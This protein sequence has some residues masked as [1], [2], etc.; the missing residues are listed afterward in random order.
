MHI[1]H[2][3][4]KIKIIILVIKNYDYYIEKSDKSSK[5]FII[6]N[7]Y[8]KCIEISFNNGLID[9]DNCFIFT[10]DNIKYKLLF[11][12]KKETHPFISMIPESSPYLCYIKNDSFYLEFILSNT[13]SKNLLYKESIIYDK[14]ND[15]NFQFSMYIYKISPS[16]LFT[17]INTYNNEMNELLF[18]FYNIKKI[19]LSD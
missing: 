7:K 15:Y 4:T 8:K 17:T 16:L 10:L 18:D 2:N 6:I 19:N 14:D 11:N 1:S 5:C 3:N 13:I 9:I 12:L